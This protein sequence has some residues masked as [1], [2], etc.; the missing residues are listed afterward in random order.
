MANPLILK[1]VSPRAKVTPHCLS[2][3]QKFLCFTISSKVRL[4]FPLEIAANTCTCARLN[5]AHFLLS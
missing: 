1:D 2:S 5:R 4:K 3:Q